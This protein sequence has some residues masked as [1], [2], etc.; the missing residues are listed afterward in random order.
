MS[1][2]WWPLFKNKCSDRTSGLTL[3]HRNCFLC[4]AACFILNGK[5]KIVASLFRL[6]SKQLHPFPYKDVWNC[7]WK[8]TIN[9][10]RLPV[11]WCT[12]SHSCKFWSILKLDGRFSAKPDD[13]WTLLPRS[14]W[15]LDGT[16]LLWTD[17]GAHPHTH[18][19][20]CRRFCFLACYHLTLRSR[21]NR[22]KGFNKGRFPLWGNDYTRQ[23]KQIQSNT[24]GRSGF[25]AA[26][27]FPTD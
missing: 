5:A 4:A 9:A 12:V 11:F 23:F 17:V 3:N 20:V 8:V 7:S 16:S 10:R 14:V 21:Q 26:S 27:Q 22:I 18:P 1:H 25:C 15:K 6:K 24:S 13:G 2:A 19:D